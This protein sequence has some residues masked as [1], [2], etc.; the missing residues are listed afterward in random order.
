LARKLAVLLAFAALALCLGASAA[1]AAN[2]T[3]TF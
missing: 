3:G 1:F 2:I